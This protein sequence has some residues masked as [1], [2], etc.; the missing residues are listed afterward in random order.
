MKCI[1][2]CLVLTL[3]S[4]S[5]YALSWK[6]EGAGALIELYTSEGCSSCPKADRWLSGLKDDAGL[7][8]N[9]VPVSFH[10]TYWDK[11]G[12]PDRFAKKE[13]TERQRSIARRWG[14][15][16]VYTPAIVIQGKRSQ[17]GETPKKSSLPLKAAW[18]GKN[19]SIESVLPE[20]AKVIIAWLGMNEHTEVKR[21]ENS[22]K[23]LSHDFI[24]LELREFD[25]KKSIPLSLSEKHTPGADALALWIEKD[26]VPVSAVGGLLQ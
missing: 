21:G 12:W 4:L 13:F 8:K 25:A 16:S 26:G 15:S 19:L 10:V 24:V 17:I 18:D 9:F 22:G 23:K 6:A 2:P 7:W 5:A 1:I 14:K 20:G 3:F 11:L